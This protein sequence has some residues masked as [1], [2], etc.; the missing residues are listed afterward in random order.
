MLIIFE[1]LISI[2]ECYFRF[3]NIEASRTITSAMKSSIEEPLFQ[4]SQVSKSPKWK[5]MIDPWFKRFKVSIN[6]NNFV[7]FC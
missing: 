1:K 7:L 2:N 4:W 3:T 6:L 5:P